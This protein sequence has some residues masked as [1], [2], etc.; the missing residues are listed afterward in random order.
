[1]GYCGIGLR[2]IDDDFRLFSD[3]LVCYPYE[4][5]SQ[6]A[7]HFHAFVDSKLREYNLQLDSSKFVVSDNEP[8][9]LAASRDKCTRIGCSD[10]FLNKQLQHL[11]E[12]TEIHLNR[13]TVEKVNCE[14]AQN[15]FLHVKNIV[16]NV[17]RSHRQQQLSMKLQ[18]YSETR[19]NGALI[20]LDV[21]RSVL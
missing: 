6:S 10:H 12:P 1:M 18:I 15:I 5:P 11:F 4:A 8:T 2:H 13:S 7:T 16:T 20:M 19:L 17:R 21:F 14:T 9:M 3:I